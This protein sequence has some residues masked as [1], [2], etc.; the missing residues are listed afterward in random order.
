MDTTEDS[1]TGTTRD[2]STTHAYVSMQYFS[3]KF[4]V[5]I[6]SS[7]EPGNVI[8]MLSSTSKN[9]EDAIGS[10]SEDML[11]VVELGEIDESGVEDTFVLNVFKND[12]LDRIINEKTINSKYLI[13]AKALVEY[14]WESPKERQAEVIMQ[15]KRSMISK[16]FANSTGI[17]NDIA[18]AEYTLR[19]LGSVSK[20]G[21]Y[22][23]TPIKSPLYIKG[24]MQ[25]IAT[26]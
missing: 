4:F 16:V 6:D 12:C 1:H 11:L 7:G 10:L 22:Y 26:N 25:K 23:F 20:S 2:E 24:L 14:I 3:P 9:R 17:L 15:V 8:L 21:K 19:S 18:A 13:D 5:N